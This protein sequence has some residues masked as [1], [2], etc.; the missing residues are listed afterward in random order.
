MGLRIGTTRQFIATHLLN[1]LCSEGR[2]LEDRHLFVEF[3][4][5]CELPHS[6]SKRADQRPSDRAFTASDLHVS[7]MP[8][9]SGTRARP[10]WIC[11]G[12][13]RIVSAQSTYSR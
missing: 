5:I 8:G 6:S 3:G 7:P 10:S 13:S 4:S 9:R 1:D 2:S 12:S 11:H